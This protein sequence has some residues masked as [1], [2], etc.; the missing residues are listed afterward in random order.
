MENVARKSM[1]PV[2]MPDVSSFQK[3]NVFYLY[4]TID[5]QIFHQKK[6]KYTMSTKKVGSFFLA[7]SQL[8]LGKIQKVRSVFEICL[9]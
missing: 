2:H 5:L 3:K 9:F 6:Y 8:L 4:T 1:V 7:I